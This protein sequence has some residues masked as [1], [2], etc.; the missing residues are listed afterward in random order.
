MRRILSPTVQVSI[1]VL[2]LTIS[3]IFVAFSFGLLPNENKVE[4]NARA[5][6]SEGLAIQL[7]GLFARDDQEGIQELVAAATGRNKDILSIAIRKSDGGLLVASGNHDRHWRTQAD[8]QSTATHVQIPL[9]SDSG[10]TGRIEISF[11]PLATGE[12]F[13]GLSHSMALF[14]GFICITGFAGYY[15]FLRRVLR[16]L[17][18]GR[19]IPER[20]KAAF[21]V[22]AEGVLIA[23][24]HGFI[25]FENRAF[26][27]TLHGGEQ[28]AAGMN[29]SLL[30]WLL[31]P[32][33]TERRLPWQIALTQ[34][35]TPVIGFQM[36]IERS[37]GNVRYLSVNSTCIADG[38][39]ITR[40]V[41][42]TFDD[43]TVL[44]ERNDQ[45]NRSMGQLRESQ[46]KI[47]QQNEQLTILASVDSLTNCLNRRA[48]FSEVTTRL[49]SARSPLTPMSVLM[50]DADHFKSINDR[51]GHAVG[52]RVLVALGAQFKL[53]CT[54]SDVV[55][56]YGGEEFCI[57]TFGRSIR[58]ANRLGEQIRASAAMA[59][60][61]LPNGESVTV[62]IGIATQMSGDSIDDV[63]RRA[64]LALY[65]AKE[66]GRNRVVALHS[67][68]IP[69]Q[70]SLPTT[71]SA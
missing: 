63:M 36:A 14:L 44:H 41:I 37:P 11:R 56:R 2:A 22:L 30:P 9:V 1:G 28:S 64:D 20:V 12:I 49:S 27:E 46:W 51:F 71:I 59:K 40:G 48:F 35:G 54:Q 58:E 61:W 18:P 8:G 24:D 31:L 68:Q 5:K 42:V 33:T 65:T 21:D 53:L 45:L 23:D 43:V 38:R 60:D 17:D 32:D 25:L 47:S 29:I 39:G 66:S 70:P 13:G 67:E 16:E 7:A 19:A 10:P 69:L 26:R 15:V 62:S 52:D 4:L 57:A 50:V 55:G 3:L 6:I 34:A